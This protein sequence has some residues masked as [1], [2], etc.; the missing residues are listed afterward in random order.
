MNKKSLAVLPEPK[1]HDDVHLASLLFVY[2][3]LLGNCGY[4]TDI[5]NYDQSDIS[6]RLQMGSS[7][8][9]D[10]FNVELR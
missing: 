3:L 1:M 4:Q 5:K 7:R 6:A 8:N 9:P 2:G 10:F